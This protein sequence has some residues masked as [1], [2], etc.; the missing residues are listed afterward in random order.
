M[1]TAKILTA[2]DMP[3]EARALSEF[4]DAQ[5]YTVI[6]A[7]DGEETLIKARVEQPDLLLLDIRMPVLDGFQVCQRLKSD[8]LTADIPIFMLTG[9]GE[10]GERVRGLSLGAEDYLI[11][12]YDFEELA[13]RIDARMRNKRSTDALRS[14]QQRILDTF[15]RYV[16]PSVVE[17]LLADPQMARLGGTRQM[18]TVLY[19]DFRGYTTLAE[20]LAPERLIGVLNSHLGVAARAILQHQGTLDKFIGDAVL[21]IFNAPLQQSD[22]ALRALRAAVALQEGLHQ[23]HET[24]AP[25]LRLPCSVG[26][27][28][29]DAVV[30]NIGAAEIVNYTAVGDV[31]NLA[32]RIEANTEDGQ[33]VFTDATYRR[34][35]DF[36]E[37]DTLGPRV[38]RGRSGSID[39]FRFTG[40]KKILIQ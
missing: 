32:Q 38:V 13:A 22:H 31:V 23:L 18:V 33:I 34:V 1:S 14:M 25:Q 29:G 28:T 7:F 36:V 10:V 5:G 27:S 39:L 35:S 20:T 4:L 30:G 17:R 9:V 11:K 37:C 12:P 40:F 24:L 6:N 8:P 26:V 21:A 19:A 16:A 3:D 2:E 15:H